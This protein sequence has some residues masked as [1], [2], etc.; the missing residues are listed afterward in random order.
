MMER[1]FICPDF[2]FRAR[3]CCL[4]FVYPYLYLLTLVCRLPNFSRTDLSEDQTE[5]EH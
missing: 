2:Y 5:R 1:V 3:C 4:F